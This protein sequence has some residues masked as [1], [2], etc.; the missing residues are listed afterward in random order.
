M[1]K[2]GSPKR[3]KD[4]ERRL[5]L[6]SMCKKVAGVLA[7]EIMRKGVFQFMFV[8]CFMMQ[9]QTSCLFSDAHSQMPVC[10]CCMSNDARHLGSN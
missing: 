4:D 8:F 9:E 5:E 7:G 10:Q 1:S 3:E 2:E 6:E